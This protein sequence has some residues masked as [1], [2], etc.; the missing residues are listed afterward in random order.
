[1][2]DVPS[3]R[4]EYDFPSQGDAIARTVHLVKEFVE[5]RPDTAVLVGAYAVGKER[6]F[7]A[8]ARELDS[9]LWTK[10]D[11]VKVWRCLQDDE[12][13]SRLVLE[14][15]E[16]RVQV[17]LL[18]PCSTS[19]L[20]VIDQRTVC[21]GGLGQ[22]LGRLGGRYRH[23]L[24]VRPTGWSHSRGE[25]SEQSLRDVRIVTKGQVCQVLLTV[26]TVAR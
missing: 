8:L 19:P 18:L 21:W 5:R 3:P 4:P 20:Q 23:V 9:K 15:E 2:L 6:V 1:M 10:D 25:G 12:I 7:K 24:G 16:A 17:N 11:R 22:E 14:R 26:L 13:L